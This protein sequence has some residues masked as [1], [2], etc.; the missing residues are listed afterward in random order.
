MNVEPTV[1]LGKRGGFTPVVFPGPEQDEDA[2][3]SQEKRSETE[4]DGSEP[5][6]VDEEG[7][8][9]PPD[10]PVDAPKRTSTRRSANTEVR[11]PSAVDESPSPTERR[12]L[13]ADSATAENVPPAAGPSR[14]T[15]RKNHPARGVSPEGRSP[16]GLAGM[17]PTSPTYSPEPV[18]RPRMMSLP[19]RVPSEAPSQSSSHASHDGAGGGAPPALVARV[20]LLE[21]IVRDDRSIQDA[22]FQTQDARL[23]TLQAGVLTANTSIQSVHNVAVS[24]D[25]HARRAE[26]AS[27]RLAVHQEE[28]LKYQRAVLDALAA[29]MGLSTESDGSASSANADMIP[30]SQV[31]QKSP[32]APGSASHLDVETIIGQAVHKAQLAFGK[33]NNELWESFKAEAKKNSASLSAQAAQD[34]AALKD[35]AA[36]DAAA[37]KEQAA[38]DAEAFRAQVQALED[39]L[40]KRLAALSITPSP[41]QHSAG[42]HLA[43]APANAGATVG[44]AASS[45]LSSNNARVLAPSS[46]SLSAPSSQSEGANAGPGVLPPQDLPGL[47]N[48]AAVSRSQRSGDSAGSDI[49]AI[50]SDEDAS[51]AQGPRKRRASEVEGTNESS[52]PPHKRHRSASASPKDRGFHAE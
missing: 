17:E 25:D 35:Q 32:D 50:E 29:R 10:P 23:Q 52:D 39:K 9:G 22:R 8:A 19:A 47:S 6:A 4:A 36:R 31:L 21:R 34:K 26:T 24:A 42:V 37:L 16:R 27:T 2:S 45:E 30:S 38:R 41:G 43:P 12:R 49:D 15:K 46:D 20:A 28:N 18:D 14:P 1:T 40:E 51:L 11:M 5:M 3:E 7:V 33:K 48:M 44:A 13:T